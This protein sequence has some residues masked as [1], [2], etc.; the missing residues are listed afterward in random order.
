MKPNFFIVIKM[1]A[2]KIF[3]SWHFI[4]LTLFTIVVGLF[5]YLM[6][7]DK[8][9]DTINTLSKLA[10]QLNTKHYQLS[11]KSFNNRFNSTQVTNLNSQIKAKNVTLTVA[12]QF[13]GSIIYRA[14]LPKDEKY[15]A[16]TFDDGPWSHSTDEILNILHQNDIKATFFMIGE[17]IKQ[18]PKLAARIVAEDHAIG[19]HTWHHWYRSLNN[20][21]AAAEIENTSNLIYQITGTRTTLFRPPGG[22]LKN[23]PAAYAKKQNYTIIMWSDDSQDYTRPS[24]KTLVNRVLKQSKPG[25][26][27]LMHDGGGNRTRTVAALPQIISQLKQKGYKFVTILE[28]LQIQSKEQNLQA[29]RL[30]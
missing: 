11:Q 12:P 5:Q 20:Q 25:G 22:I 23:G 9:D 17:N 16:L 6:L 7:N 27:I 3:V 18:Y 21:T 13:A 1:K 24:V 30:R 14:K 8:Y 29:F 28:L 19:N 4:S 15:I 26:I 2:K 10:L